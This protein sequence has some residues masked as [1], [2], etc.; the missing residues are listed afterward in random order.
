MAKMIDLTGYKKEDIEIKSLNDT[1]YTIPGNFASEFFIKIYHTQTTIKKLKETDF[2]KAFNV[3]KNWTL[4][5]LSLDKSKTVTI[6]TIN[7]EFND[8]RVLEKL[9]TSIM[10][11]ANE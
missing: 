2:E 5:L 9:L 1:V 3:L 11:F 6:E 8:F 7:T 4:E 10:Q